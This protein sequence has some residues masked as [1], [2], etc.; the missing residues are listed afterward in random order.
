[1]SKI[2]CRKKAEKERK[3]IKRKW[4][5]TTKLKEEEEGRGGEGRKRGRKRNK[6]IQKRNKKEEERKRE[7]EERKRQGRRK[8]R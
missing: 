5:R 7:E 8:H 6:E 2:A 1:L 3:M 4:K